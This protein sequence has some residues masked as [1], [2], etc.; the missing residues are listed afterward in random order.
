MTTIAYESEELKLYLA[1]HTRA[2]RPAPAHDDMLQTS[3][4]A[5]LVLS[6]RPGAYQAFQLI[7]EPQADLVINAVECEGLAADDEFTCL[8]TEGVDSAGNSFLRPVRV[9]G[10]SPWPL[11]CMVRL[12]CAGMRHMR[13]KLATSMGA[14]MVCADVRAAGDLDEDAGTT[15]GSSLSRL[16]WLNSRRGISDAIPQ[17]FVP[18]MRTANRLSVLG[19]D[20]VIG[21]DG[22][23]AQIYTHFSGNNARIGAEARPILASPLAFVVRRAGKRLELEPLELRFT[24][25]TPQAV[26]W[27]AVSVGCDVRMQVEGALE[28]DGTLTLNAWLSSQVDAE[29]EVE[30]EHCPAPGYDGLFIGLG[31]NGGRTPRQHAWKW[32]PEKRQDAYW[33]GGV[34]GGLVVKPRD[35][36][37]EQPFVNLYYHHGPR[38][39]PVNWVNAGRGGFDMS[40]GRLR[41]YSGGIA[42][43]RAARLF[44][45]EL[46]ISPF[47]P[48]DQ[49]KQFSTRYYHGG[50]Y[51]ED[52]W[53]QHAHEN[54]CTHINYHH[55]NDGYPFIN[56]PM[57][58]DEKFH[59]LIADAHAVGIG[60][61]PY[62]T[63]RELTSRLPEFWALRSL[64]QEIYPKPRYKFDGITFQGGTDDF[65]RENLADEVIPAW[66]HVFHDGPYAGESDPSLIT[67]PMSRLAN[68]HVEGLYYM[69]RKWG[70]D[71]IYIDDVGYDRSIM[72][73][74]RRVLDE[75]RPGSL[76]DLHSWNHFEDK[77]GAGW[78]HN[79][80]L[81]AQLMPYLDSLWLGEGFDYEHT[82]AEYILVEISGIPFGLMSEMLQDGGNPWRGMLYGMTNRFPYQKQTPRPIWKLRDEFGFDAV[83]MIGFWDDALPVDTGNDKVKCTV[84]K[85]DA[86]Q[87]MLICFASFADEPLEIVPEGIPQ[88]CRAFYPE[89]EDM[90]TRGAYVGGAIRIVPGGG[91]I[92]W[93]E[94]DT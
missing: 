46:M 12:G 55:G 81:Y 15:D 93:V 77:M 54:G 56:Y 90:Q 49:Q 3:T 31:V 30:F 63:V 9:H 71:G 62:Y 70:I 58:D 22:C 59:S 10:G 76:I 17:P 35:P 33:I 14:Y 86:A 39:L 2:F 65:I 60:L 72:R 37:M 41:Y 50:P 79:A 42:L 53:V 38:N 43:T 84:Y 85:N 5:G 1:D 52:R 94:H 64:G 8:A 68:F 45:V 61:K 40:A 74:I 6:G 47:K 11:W 57:Y 18:I 4:R 91:A 82:S 66:K 80:L 20:A 21:L 19:R 67:N 26:S 27:Q 34:N 78:G 13:L 48:V 83:E 16:S 51:K 92:L 44:G 75:C 7:V 87:R 24:S 28:F 29:Y 32:D 36:D 25:Q 23:P 69:C 88:G 73:R 89:M